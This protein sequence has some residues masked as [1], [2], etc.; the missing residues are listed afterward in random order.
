MLY[1]NNMDNKT[2]KKYR[3]GIALF[4]A[5]L[6]SIAVSLDNTLLAL[7]SVIIGM[8]FS[9]VVR[10]KTK[11]VV[12][13]RE[14]MIRQKAAQMAYAIFAPTIGLGSLLLILVSDETSYFT[15]AIGIVLS[16]LTLFLIALFSIF[17]YY[18]NRKYGGNGEE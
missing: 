14:V 10:S 3:I 13:E 6:M 15:E 11:H 5:I 9:V 1:I 8:V 4:V 16:Y 17:L 12:D 18:F 2:Y 7:S